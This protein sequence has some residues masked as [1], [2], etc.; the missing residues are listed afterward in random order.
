MSNLS[1]LARSLGLMPNMTLP[2][3]SFFEPNEKFWAAFEAYKHLK[4][5]DCGCGS[6][7]LL[8]AA[9][10]RGFNMKGV[11]I[12]RREKQSSKVMQ[13]DATLLPWSETQWP[14]ICRPSHDGW[15]NDV[16]DKALIHGAHVLWVGK[17]NNYEVDSLCEYKTR[18]L[19]R[20][21]GSDKETLYLLSSSW[22]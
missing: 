7:E 11:D 2:S 19:A 14:L 4:L 3:G 15:A 12:L 21:V 18:A 13:A 10:Q 17:P 6:G 1:S 5:I 16:A 8:E 20:N 9:I 22:R